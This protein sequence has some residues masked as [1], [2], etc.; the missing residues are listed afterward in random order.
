M[1]AGERDPAVVAL[2]TLAAAELWSFDR[3]RFPAPR[4]VFLERWIDRVGVIARGLVSDG[5]LVGYAVA[6]PPHKSYEFLPVFART[7]DVARRLI[8]SILAEAPGEQV[9]LNLPEANTAG[10]AR[11]EEFEWKASFGCARLYLGPPPELPLDDIFGLTSF[12]FG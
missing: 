7:Q 4:E 2:R 12:E 3:L 10:V 9:Q 5:A 6:R 1:A 8:L 11:A